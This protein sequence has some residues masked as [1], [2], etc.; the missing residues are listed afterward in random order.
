MR[1]PF[2][3]CAIPDDLVTEQRGLG[4]LLD[5]NNLACELPDVNVATLVAMEGWLSEGMIE[6]SSNSPTATLAGNLPAHD[7]GSIYPPRGFD[8]AQF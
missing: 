2:L 5:T 7:I 6:G 3:G 4:H 8:G 1:R